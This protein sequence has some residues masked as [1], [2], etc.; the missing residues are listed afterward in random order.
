MFKLNVIYLG[1]KCIRSFNNMGVLML[2]N[3]KINTVLYGAA[4]VVLAVI[5]INLILTFTNVNDVKNKI[6][7]KRTEILPHAFNFLNLKINVIQVQQWLTDISATRAKEGFDD[8]F[9][10]AENY[11]NAGNKLLDHMIAEHIKYQEPEMVQELKDFKS[12]FANYYK[13][14]QKMAH[15]YIDFG[16][17]EGN[18]M[19]LELDPYAEKLS[20]KL[21]F[22]IKEHMEEN[23]KAADKIAQSNEYILHQTLTTG[24]LLIVTIIA[25]FLAIG[26]IIVSIKSIHE[27]LKKMEGLDLSEELKIEGK[28]EIAD[29][30]ISLNTVTKEISKVLYSIHQT[31]EE[32]VSISEQLTKSSMAVG[33]NIKLSSDIVIETTNT[34]KDIQDEIVVYVEEAKKTK[35]EVVKANEKLNVAKNEIINISQ[36]VHKASELETEVTHKIQTLSQEAEQVKEVLTVINDIADQTNLLALN[37]AIEAARAG[38][39]GRGFA[40]VADEVRKL[41]ERTQ[42][43]LSEIS[44]TINVIVQSIMEISSEM[45]SNSKDIE[46]LSIVSQN[47]QASIGEV[48]E[49]MNKAV[50]SND[51]STN[52]F[53][54]TGE[55]MNRVR[56]EVNKINEFSQSNAT[57]ASEMSD[58]STHLLNLTSKLNEQIDKFKT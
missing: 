15:T 43:S 29:I 27:H 50:E 4:G 46:E 7:E 16:A 1:I 34:T 35:E 2:K 44:A 53:I 31:S 42:K 8:G 36:K 17:E 3:I 39:H 13:I 10:E 28:N 20:N 52:N 40:V 22:W 24:F 38:E 32:N 12:N 49:V 11:F 9:S 54:V 26:A 21:E 33:N 23:E 6:V 30:A 25:A 5:M 18:K 41:A 58:A 47:I 51:E 48:T 19:M 37:A 55:H 56:D 57:S 14:G 45:N